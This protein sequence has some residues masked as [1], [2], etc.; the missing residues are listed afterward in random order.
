MY[1][2][3]H[4][5]DVTHT[6]EMWVRTNKRETREYF[7]YILANFSDYLTTYIGTR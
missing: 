3:W 5:D 4:V 7:T 1:R 6:S 2:F